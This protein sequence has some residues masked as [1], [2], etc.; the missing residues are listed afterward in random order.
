VNDAGDNGEADIPERTTIDELV[1]ALAQELSRLGNT[2][3]A[4]AMA[5]YMKTDM[6][7][8]GVKAP[9]RKAAAR[10]VF[11]KYSP[12][13][14]AEF[15]RLVLTLWQR[16]ERELKYTA[17]NVAGKW[18]R[19]LIPA[20]LPLFERLVR[21]GQWWDFVDEI[22]GYVSLV[23]DDAPEE[24][25]PVLDA[26]LID[27]NMWIRRSA[28]LGQRKRKH[29]TEPDRL[30]AYALALAPEHEFFIR[31]AIG[32]ALRDYGKVDPDAVR[33]FLLENRE[34]FAPLTFREA[35]KHLDMTD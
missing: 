30:F 34:R 31:K 24:V 3:D 4:E 21:E 10:E 14:R 35:A 28:M 7:F 8:F 19:W 27:D 9:A 1:D 5:A 2:E 25:W 33:A 12:T 23:L 26:W 16:D 32:W 11:A 6:P 20:S 18:K 22:A 17:L 13:D 15:E 29:S